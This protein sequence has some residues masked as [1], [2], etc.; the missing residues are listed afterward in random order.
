MGRAH[1]THRGADRIVRD[2]LRGRWLAG[3]DAGPGLPRW[4]LQTCGGA[5][6][7]LGQVLAI[8]YDV[9][10]GRYCD[11]LTKL[12]DRLPAM[13]VDVIRA[14]IERDP[15]RTLEAC[16]AEFDPEPLGS[17]SIAQVHGAR[18]HDG[19]EVV[20]KVIRPATRRTFRIDFRHLHS[21]AAALDRFGPFTK[22]E[23]R[24]L[25]QEVVDLMREELDFRREA[26]NIWQM[27]ERDARRWAGGPHR[28]AAVPEL[29]RR[30]GHHDGAHA[31]GIGARDHAGGRC[32]RPGRAGAMGAGG[33]RR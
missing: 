33:H 32:R 3:R 14:A 19:D 1:C 18:L 12:L 4:Y 13:P 27:Q 20:V 29:V 7:K 23:A 25:V 15:G 26:R 2:R 22:L 30:G 31:R 28:S 8:R 21:L 24:R 11:E 10:P 6:V 17:A 16:Y 5:F 9:L